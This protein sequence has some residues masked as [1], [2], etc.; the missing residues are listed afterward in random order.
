MTVP[1]LV[2]HCNDYFL[3]S[4]QGLKSMLVDYK[5][6]SYMIVGQL[7]VKVVMERSL[8]DT[9]AVHISKSL[10]KEPVLAKEGL[11]CLIVL[12]QNQK[13]GAVGPR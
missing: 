8:V 13:D 6:A 3:M 1:A 7:A 9:L 10:L 12:L 5:A 11:G 2:P 4:L